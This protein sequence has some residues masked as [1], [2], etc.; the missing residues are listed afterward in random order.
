MRSPILF[1]R[2]RNGSMAPKL[3][4]GQLIMATRLF[5]KLHAGQVV[6][7]ERDNKQFVKRIERIEDD[8][9]F[10]IGDNLAASVDS[11]QFGWL[12]R[13]AVVARVFRPNLAK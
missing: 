2:V 13:R 3:R 10:V 9:L 4:P 12:D 7:V 5:R 11:R 8:K 6:I 1:R